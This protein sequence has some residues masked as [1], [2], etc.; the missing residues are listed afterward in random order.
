MVVDRCESE[1]D[2]DLDAE[3]SKVSAIKLFSIVHCHIGWYSELAYDPL[4]DEAYQCSRCDFCQGFRLYPLEKYSK[5]VV[6]KQRLPGAGGSGPTISM[7]H[8]CSGQV[9]MMDLVGLAGE[10]CFL[11]NI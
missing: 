1:F 4:P 2:V 8:H 5:A 11:A 9:G 3:I 6:A 10:S 7:P